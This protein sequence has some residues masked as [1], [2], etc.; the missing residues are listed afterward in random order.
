MP[1]LGD[2]FTV[3]IKNAHIAWGTRRHSPTRNITL[4]EGYIQIPINF[5]RQFQIFNSNSSSTSPIYTC[6]SI[7]GFLQNEEL[8]ASGSSSSGDIHAKQFQGH[9]S[10][11]TIGE[12]YH[13]VDA[14]VGD[15]IRVVF[16]GQN[17]MTIELIRNSQIT[18]FDL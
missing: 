15:S 6:S 4:G 14:R 11:Q 8:L 17:S 5:A 2:S 3:E 1:N 13:Q 9:G 10:L 16:T 12:W 7:D 18:L